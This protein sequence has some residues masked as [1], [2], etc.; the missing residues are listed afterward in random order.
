MDWESFLNV[1]GH[2]SDFLGIIS[3][4]VSVAL[5]II[6]LLGFKKFKEEIAKQ[7]L[8]YAAQREGILK[9]LKVYYS[10]MFKDMQQDDMM[11]GAIRQQIFT[12]KDRFNKLLGDDKLKVINEIIEITDKEFMNINLSTLQR[13]IDIIISAFEN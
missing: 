2:V 6:K 8:K 13:K 7:E 1:V 4:V 12:I 5:W 11:I 9:D 10:S 3:V